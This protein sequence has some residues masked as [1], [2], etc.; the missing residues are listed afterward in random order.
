MVVYD[1]HQILSK[2]KKLDN[3]CSS[4]FYVHKC[5]VNLVAINMNEEN[6]PFFKKT[7]LFRRDKQR[8][9]ET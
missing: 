8:E 4:L 1:S 9:A 6:F 3:L 2:L 5:T 7:Y